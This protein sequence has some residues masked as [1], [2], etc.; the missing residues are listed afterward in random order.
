[1]QYANVYFAFFINTLMKKNKKKS[2]KN[3]NKEKMAIIKQEF[4]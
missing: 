3:T 2:K 4:R 1:M